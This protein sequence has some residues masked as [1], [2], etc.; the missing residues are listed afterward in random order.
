MFQNIIPPKGTKKLLQKWRGP[1]MIT[2]V[3]Q[4]G[5]FYRL[6]TGRAAHYEIRHLTFH[7]RCV[8]QNMEGLEYLLVEPACEVNEKG[9]REKN[10]GNENV[11]MN[12]NEK[13]EVDVVKG[14]FAEEDWIYPEQKEVPKWTEPDLQMTKETRKGG[15]KR[16]GMRYNRYGDDFLIDKIQPEETGEE[17]VNVSELVA[18][19]ERQIINDSEHSLQEDH[20][21]PEREMKLE[22]SEIERRENTHRDTGY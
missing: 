19:E 21:M 9:T 18:N 14:S 1:F 5:R 13:I 6:S 2:E 8:P 7:Q 20:T 4:Q 17:L 3:H 16:T 11:S 22:H 10:D 15:R 12:D